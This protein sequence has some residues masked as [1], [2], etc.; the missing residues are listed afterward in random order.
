MVL[1]SFSQKVREEGSCEFLQDNYE[2]IMSF[3]VSYFDYKMHVY[4]VVLARWSDVQ[5]R[6]YQTVTPL[7][8]S[9]KL[10]EVQEWVFEACICNDILSYRSLS[11]SVKYNGTSNCNLPIIFLCRIPRV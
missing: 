3:M 5:L 2:S 4:I 9:K 11:L 8:M 6:L 7:I 1:G 10:Y